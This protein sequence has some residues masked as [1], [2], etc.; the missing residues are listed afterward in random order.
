[1]KLSF[2]F[3]RE[4]RE[5]L[6]WCLPALIIGLALRMAMQIAMPYGYIQY[7]TADFLLTPF[8][9]LSR[10]RFM[11]H[12]KKAFLS[13]VF[14]T[15][16]FLLHIPAL[17][18]IPIAQHIMG[19]IE[20]LCAGALVRLWFPLWRWIIIPATLL[21]G[22]YP[23]QLWYEQT[24]MGEAN[25]VFFLFVVALAGT[26]WAARP[27]WWRFA[28]FLASLFCVCGTRAEGKIII[29]FA[30][31]LIP[32][33]LWRRWKSLIA[34]MVCAILVFIAANH[35][36]AGGDHAFSLLYATLFRFSPDD[37]QSEPG[38]GPYLLP[39]RDKIRRESE[40]STG[41][42]EL[43]KEIGVQVTTYL[44]EKKGIPKPG[45][46]D[47]ADAEKRLCIEIL[48]HNPTLVFTLPINK[49]RLASDAWPTGSRFDEQALH[50]WQIKA[51][52][53]GHASM[54]YLRPGLT[55]QRPPGQDWPT[56]IL[57]HYD[58]ARMAWFD[59]YQT[60]WSQCSVAIRL[61]DRP[62]T[63]VRIV[64]DFI[65]TIPNAYFVEPGVPLYFLLAFAGMAAAL[66]IPGPLRWAQAAWIA[67]ML[68]TW[69]A[70]TTVGVTNARFRFAYEPF[71]YIYAV[72]AVV[73]AV[74]GVH[75]LWTSRRQ[76]EKPEKIPS[77][78][79]P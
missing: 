67:G 23:W 62:L 5:V 38:I 45:R 60:A 58:P 75:R 28:A 71:C 43:A 78:V 65:S 69:A 22:I 6:L 61:P 15:I 44:H 26:W 68:L 54:I 73:W 16:P 76:S 40:V 33:V 32:L 10:H 52:G 49:F 56:F 51:A 74:A 27:T 9:Y 63:S 31:A 72:A 35:T 14:F 64:H 25:Y 30:I 53:R 47:V 66:F 21:V 46:V 50:P 57:A 29:S 3:P 17:F 19:L 24:L 79:A 70:A 7:D 20:I 41:L 37:F 77:T 36:G 12:P 4:V 1:M 18:F 48:Q 59:S 8:R 11:V 39:L 34:A 42:V 2:S 13:P 55:G